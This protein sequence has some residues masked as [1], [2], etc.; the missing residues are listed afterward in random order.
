M[1]G[2]TNYENIVDDTNKVEYCNRLNML[3]Y[4]V[5]FSVTKLLSIQL[6]IIVHPTVDMEIVLDPGDVKLR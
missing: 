3:Q 2:L 6:N 1:S 4:H 5:T